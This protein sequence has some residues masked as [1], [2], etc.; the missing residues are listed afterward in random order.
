MRD[1]I[2]RSAAPA[3]LSHAE[4]R[5]SRSRDAGLGSSSFDPSR[6]IGEKNNIKVMV[7][8]TKGE[9]AATTA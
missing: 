5:G 2:A 4:P 9:A 7:E 6:K 1:I 8:Q 3:G